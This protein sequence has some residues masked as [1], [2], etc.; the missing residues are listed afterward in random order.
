M[1]WADG[2]M[3]TEQNPIYFAKNLQVGLFKDLTYDFGSDPSQDSF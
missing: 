2:E 1:V 3:S